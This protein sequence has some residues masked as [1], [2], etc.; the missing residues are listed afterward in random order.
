MKRFN[1]KTTGVLSPSDLKGFKGRVIY[2]T[3]FVLLV[4]VS[5]ISLVPAIWTVLTSFKETK[6]IYSAFSFLPEI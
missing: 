3:F 4:M 1:S 6:E 2:W 5:L